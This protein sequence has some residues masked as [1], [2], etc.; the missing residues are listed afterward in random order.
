MTVLGLKPARYVEW[1]TVVHEEALTLSWR[2]VLWAMLRAVIRSFCRIG[3]TRASLT[4]RQRMRKCARC[5]IYDRGLHRCRPFTGSPVGCGCWMPGKA[6]FSD[7]GWLTEVGSDKA[8]T[9]CW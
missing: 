3:N 1:W 6:A 4:W 8:D 5:P 9:F 7:H 2:R